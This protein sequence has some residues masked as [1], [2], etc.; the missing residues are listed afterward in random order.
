VN[1]T[2]ADPLRQEQL[3]A[4]R[5]WQDFWRDGRFLPVASCPDLPS[6]PS[7]VRVDSD[8]TKIGERNRVLL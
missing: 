1:Q 8:D 7:I 6:E 5:R 2:G 4:N 3:G